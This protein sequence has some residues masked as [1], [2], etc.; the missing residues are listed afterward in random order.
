MCGT[1]HCCDSGNVCMICANSERA[2]RYMD[3]DVVWKVN[4]MRKG[5]V[6]CGFG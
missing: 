1:T 2:I 5:F 3:F 4:V 6:D